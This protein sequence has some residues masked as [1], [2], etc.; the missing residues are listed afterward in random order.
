[1]D[2]VSLSE[3]REFHSRRRRGLTGW[4]TI[5]PAVSRPYVVR[6]DLR[7][8]APPMRHHLSAENDLDQKSQDF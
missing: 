7:R 8:R 1:M 5:V 6:E 2:M 4:G 3:Y